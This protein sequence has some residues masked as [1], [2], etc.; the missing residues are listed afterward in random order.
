MLKKVHFKNYRCFE[1]S[2]S[3][4]GAQRLLWDKTT[5]ENLPSLKRFAFFLQLHKN[6]NT[7]IMCHPLRVWDFP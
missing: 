4:F 2:E 7:Q 1:N 5:Q 3:F 6:L